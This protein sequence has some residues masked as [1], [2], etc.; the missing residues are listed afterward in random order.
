MWG[1]EPRELSLLYVLAYVAGAGNARTPGSFARLIGTPRAAQERRLVG[2]SQLIAERVAERLGRRVL[3]EAPVRRIVRDADGVQVSAGGMT[4]RARRAIVAVPPVLAAE[5]RYVPALPASKRAILRA[6][7]PG[8]LSKAEA[9]YP[10]P[11]WRDAQL[12]GQAVSDVGIAR[13]VFDNSPPD[14]SVGVLF[15]FIGGARHREWKALAPAVRRA[16]VLEDF[17]RFFGDAAGSP[18][19]YLEHDWTRERWTRG[20]PVGHLAPGVLRRHGPALRQPTG[21]LHWAGTE[22]SDYW[23]GYMDGAV[24]AGE[25]AAAEV[26][27]RLR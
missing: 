8:S 13:S 21:R 18:V 24:R 27:A 2:G 14:G 10:R 16:R 15:S 4:V 25:R 12:S 19:Q 22:T 5:I 20:C 3:L 26:L 23:L 7:G 17:V 6:M 11:F 9:V 1:A